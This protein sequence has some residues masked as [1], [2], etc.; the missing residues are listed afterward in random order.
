MGDLRGFWGVCAGMK[1]DG[2]EGG[3][4]G[5]AGVLFEVVE[6]VYDETMDGFL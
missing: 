4:Y 3:P 1:D 6:G 2:G 5:V